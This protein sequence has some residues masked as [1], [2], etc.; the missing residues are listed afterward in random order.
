[1]T[2]LKIPTGPNWPMGLLTIRYSCQKREN[3]LCP[4]ISSSSPFKYGPHPLPACRQLLPCFVFDKLPSASGES[5]H[6]LCHW[7]PADR[8]SLHLGAPT[9]SERH[10]TNH[11]STC[12]RLLWNNEDPKIQSPKLDYSLVVKR[13]PPEQTPRTWAQALSHVNCVDSVMLL[14]L[15]EPHFPHLQN[16]TNINT[17]LTGLGRQAAHPKF[18]GQGLVDG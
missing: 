12:E 16:E 5:F 9:Q 17:Y 4:H 11:P 3:T 18:K 6:C 13:W 8:V 10:P 1:M 7:L 14:S 15:S 2:H